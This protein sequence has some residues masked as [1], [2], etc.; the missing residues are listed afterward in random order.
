MA[1]VHKLAIY[2]CKEKNNCYP[3]IWYSLKQNP[4]R[5]VIKKSILPELILR[6]LL[7]E[8]Y[9]KYI[10]VLLFPTLPKIKGKVGGGK[11]TN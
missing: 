7:T 3:V 11:V 4:S 2:S 8:V 9:N 6:A 10:N 1:L 5:Q